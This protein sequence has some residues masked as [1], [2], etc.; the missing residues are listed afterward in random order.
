MSGSLFGAEMLR[1]SRGMG[2]M[3]TGPAE[4]EYISCRGR[5]PVS[6]LPRGN[7]LGPNDPCFNQLMASR[8]EESE[9]QRQLPGDP[10]GTRGSGQ[11]PWRSNGYYRPSTTEASAT[12]GQVLMWLAIGAAVAVLGGMIFGIGRTSRPAPESPA[13]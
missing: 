2:S 12:G 13:G 1:L 10:Y 3:G 9:R 8:I 11:D 7:E 4:N 6:S 5:N